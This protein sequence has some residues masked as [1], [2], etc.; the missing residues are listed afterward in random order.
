M[1]S[2]INIIM[3]VKV[4]SQSV[5]SAV[6]QLVLMVCSVTDVYWIILAAILKLVLQP[7]LLQTL[8]WVLHSQMV[9]VNGTSLTPIKTVQ[10][11]T[12][13]NGMTI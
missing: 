6:I 3:V 9:L 1:V 11:V 13:T 12:I 4:Q 7:L 2:Q 5:I 10:L 8:T